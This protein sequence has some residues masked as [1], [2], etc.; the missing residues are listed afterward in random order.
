MRIAYSTRPIATWVRAVRRMP[1]TEMMSKITITP[2]L[3]AMFG[4]VLTAL[5]PAMASSD[6]AR[7]TTPATAAI[8]LAAIISHPV[9]NPRYGLIARPT[10]SKE[11]PQF[12]FHR[13]SR[14]YAL[15]MISIGTPHK[16]M[17]GAL[18]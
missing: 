6:G 17:T 12:A 4:Q 15:A 8:R 7:I 16:R 13:F 5:T 18:P 11:A 3:M 2:V 1:A 10:H 14:R 9:R